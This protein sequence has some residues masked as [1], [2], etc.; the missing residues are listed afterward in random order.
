MRK[1]ICLILITILLVTMTA[2]GAKTC[3]RCGVKIEGDPVEAGGRYYCS[4]ECYWMEAL[5]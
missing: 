4:Y 5:S 2:C 3:H 1:Q